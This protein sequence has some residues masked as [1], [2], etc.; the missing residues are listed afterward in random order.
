MH[1]DSKHARIYVAGHR[2]LLGSAIVRRFTRD[3][4]RNLL[5]RDRCALDL[6]DQAA[7]NGFFAEH[8]PE[9]VILAA[10]RVG[11]ILANDTYPADFIGDN[12]AIQT[13][14]LSAALS[15]IHI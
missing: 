8:K 13:N 5:F 7:V 14:V 11:G 4:Y 12:L 9:F 15:L 1:L 2:G 10:A 3:G 6:R